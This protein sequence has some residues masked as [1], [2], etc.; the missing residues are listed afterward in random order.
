MNPG[1]RFPAAFTFVEVLA[2]LAF[3]GILM[4]VVLRG[5]SAAT[6]FIGTTGNQ[7]AAVVLAGNLISDL[8][9]ADGWRFSALEGDSGPE[10]PGFSWRASLD[11]WQPDLGMERPV[12]VL[13][14]AVTVSWEERGRERTVSLRTLVPEGGSE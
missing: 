5:V 12:P 10:R 2:A 3:T 9:I 11:S 7:R 6:A 1:K 8:V 13:E 14:L 4:P